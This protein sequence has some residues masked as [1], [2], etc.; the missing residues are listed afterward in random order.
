MDHDL[1]LAEHW[2]RA[3]YIQEQLADTPHIA[4]ERHV[5][6]NSLSNGVMVTVD[7]SALGKSTPNVIK[8]LKQG[9]PSIWVR[10]FNN[11]FRIAV[12]HLVEDEIDTVI[13]RLKFILMA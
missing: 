5:E 12:A 4:T 6:D 2:R 7:E 13:S 10:G 9:D 1:R 8:E 11:R 3:D